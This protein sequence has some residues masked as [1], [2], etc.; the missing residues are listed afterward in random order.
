MKKVQTVLKLK[1]QVARKKLA[2]APGKILPGYARKLLRK[3]VRQ[4]RKAALRAAAAQMA[5]IYKSD[6]ELTALSALDGEDFLTHP[7]PK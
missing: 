1:D 6:R 3:H 5:K 2:Q 7:A 4:N